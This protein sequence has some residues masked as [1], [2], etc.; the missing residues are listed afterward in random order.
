MRRLTWLRLL[1][2]TAFF[3]AFGLSPTSALARSRIK[4][5]VDFE[6]VRENMLVGYGIVVGLAGTGDTLNNSPFT[7]QIWRPCWSVWASTPVTPP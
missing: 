7:R 6:G 2:V 4:D 5:I 3:A 1:I